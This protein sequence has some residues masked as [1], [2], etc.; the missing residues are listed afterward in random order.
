MPLVD[1]GVIMQP[2][3][4]GGA[5]MRN[6]TS[7]SRRSFAKLIGAGAATAVVRPALAWAGAAGPRSISTAT[8]TLVRLNSNENPYG[9]SPMALKAMTDA[10]SMVWRS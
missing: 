6:V 1:A 5:T 4:R 2:D 9:P 10:F 7:L 8:A 3:Y